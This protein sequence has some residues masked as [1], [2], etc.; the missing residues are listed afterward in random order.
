MIQTCL[1]SK[2]NRSLVGA[3][4]GTWQPFPGGTVGWLPLWGGGW[5]VLG[6][7]PGEPWTLFT[8]KRTQW[9]WLRPPYGLL[10]KALN[11][12]LPQPSLVSAC[13]LLPQLLLPPWGLSLIGKILFGALHSAEPRNYPV[14]RH[15][16]NVSRLLTADSNEKSID[17]WLEMCPFLEHEVE[18]LVLNTC[19][20]SYMAT[21][22]WI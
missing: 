19:V 14:H 1:T 15:A 3:P 16:C 6:G 20:S 22:P 2:Y 10:L 5:R 21:N 8:Q 7:C 9:L 11:S 13:P 18:T 17:C 4:G 12:Y